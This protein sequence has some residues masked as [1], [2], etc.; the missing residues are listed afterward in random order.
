MSRISYQ[1]QNFSVTDGQLSVHLHL[2]KDAS[3]TLHFLHGNGFA[4]RTYDALLEGIV[5]QDNLMLQDAAGHGL[6]PAGEA[7]VGWERSSERFQSLL[8][9]QRAEHD[10]SKVIGLGH[11]FG[12]C[13][14]LLMSARQ[15]D[16]FQ[17]NVLLDPAFYPPEMIEQLM[18]Q[19]Q[20]GVSRKSLLVRQTERRRT[21][22]Q[23]AQE[24]V[25]SLRGRGAFVGWQER[26]LQD[27]VSASTHDNATGER[28]LNCPPW[29]EAALFGSSPRSLWPAL[30]SINTPTFVLWG[31]AT[32][33]MFQTSYRLAQTLNP[34]LHFI[35]VQGDHCFMMQ[36]PKETAEL[37]RAII[38]RG[39]EGVRALAHSDFIISY[40][41]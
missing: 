9:Q 31:T 22:W 5:A 28:E 37:V 41:G 36:Y 25:D 18:A 26:C 40:G 38:D 10:W 11:S 34:N 35:E 30:E 32:H 7:F 4:V 1:Q 2:L 15:P 27:Y 6:S 23:N 29:L 33:E 3:Q 20:Q 39:E 21:H 16:L 24:V 19:A 13:M 12:G 8:M 14:T 17:K